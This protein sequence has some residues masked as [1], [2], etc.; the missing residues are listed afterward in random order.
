[1][2]E[3]AFQKVS[4]FM[5]ISFLMFPATDTLSRFVGSIH[6]LDPCE[7]LVVFKKR[8][9]LVTA[10]D[11]LDAPHPKC[12]LLGSIARK[13][14][15]LSREATILEAVYLMISNRLRAIPIME[16]R[17]VVGMISCTDVLRAIMAS[18]AFDD[19]TCKDAMKL[20]TL[21]VGVHEKV[22]TA[23]SIMCRHDVDHLLVM[24]EGGQFEGTITA[25][26]IVLNFIQPRESVTQGEIIGESV[27]VWDASVRE[28]MDADPLIVKEKDPLMNVMESFRKTGKEVCVVEGS[29]GIGII[30]PMEA[31]ALLL[32]FKVRGLIHVRILGLPPRGDFLSIWTIQDKIN[33]VLS[34]GFTFHRGVKE[35]IIDVKPKKQSGERTLYQI[36]AR[37]YS[38]ARPLVV[39]AHGWY[40]A[41]AFDEL[42]DKLGRVLRK[43]KRRRVRAQRRYVSG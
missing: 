3:I 30:T 17:K 34:M 19:I 43:S 11:V 6:P 31:I 1:M 12:T 8:M 38:S 4:Q 24:N 16:G 27:R 2:K 9:G 20:S 26:D 15:S 14:S 22:S 35:V 41:E 21:S 29:E 36:I 40:L 37:V 25:K 18:S 5:R 10:V 28:L 13:A 33:R 39:T 7:A 23:R 42:H 32:R